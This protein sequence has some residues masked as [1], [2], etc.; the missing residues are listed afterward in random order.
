[1]RLFLCHNGKLHVLPSTL[2][3][4]PQTTPSILKPLDSRFMQSTME[5]TA[6]SMSL[7]IKLPCMIFYSD[8]K[9]YSKADL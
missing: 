2:L 9:T 1:M 5:I 4:K 8:N 3:S 7:K 6:I